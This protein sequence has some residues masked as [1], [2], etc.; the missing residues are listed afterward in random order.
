MVTTEHPVVLAQPARASRHFSRLYRVLIIAFGVIL[1]LSGVGVVFLVRY[2]PFDRKQIV[3]TLQETVPGA[4]VEVSRFHITYFPHPGCRA[5]GVVFIRRASPPGFPPLVTI[6][7][8][9]IQADYGDLFLRPG[10]ISRIMLDG[11][12]IQVPP[13]GSSVSSAQSFS[14]SDPISARTVIGEID[15][16]GALLEIGRRNDS[17]LKFEIHNIRLHSVGLKKVM[18]YSVELRNPL[19][20]G[21]IRS[22]GKI[23]PWRPHDLGQIPVSG[24][25]K[26]DRA[27]L[28][29]FSGIQGQLSSTGKFAG[30]LAEI[31]VA[32][33]TDVPD[34]AV[35]TNG[36]A[37]P[38]KSRFQAQVD[39]TNG[40]V[41][42]TRMS[43]L[44]AETPVEV[45]GSILGNPGVPG[46]ATSLDLISNKGR[47]QDVL[48][49][50]AKAPIPPMSGPM[51]FRAHV[52]LVD[53]NRRF[54]K[55]VSLVGDFSIAGGRF[56][57]PK[58]QHSVD[59][60]SQ[61]SRE[62]KNKKDDADPPVVVA[63]LSGHVNLSDG[64]ARFSNLSFDVP[65]AV[66]QMNGMFNVITEKVDFHGSL[67]TDAEL[68]QTTH[69]IKAV[70]LKPLDPIFKRKRHGA[71]IPIEMTG[72]YSQPHFGMEI[73]PKR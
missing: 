16:D 31:D 6:Q 58:T 21:E 54:L 36:H 45:R 1:L 65:G 35:K 63:N 48:R 8:L 26:F 59:Q 46:K 73:L 66:A 60:L 27:D 3:E 72:T 29:V 41:Q 40:D 55:R 15:S 32:G 34:F 70:L 7:K 64:F 17:P 71:V 14:Q 51:N 12:H 44:L 37:F 20:P 62:V 5:E 47:V 22:A 49:P 38:L 52:L 57:K 23:G 39:G 2:W 18:S 24:D 30:R 68:S 28:G 33:A 19:P 67:K 9:V 56:A 10:Y 69:G 42:V 25:Y 13:R 11:L 4:K 43:V 50:F 61:S 53:N